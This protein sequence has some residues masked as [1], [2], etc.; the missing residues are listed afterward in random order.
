MLGQLFSPVHSMPSWAMIDADADGNRDELGLL[1]DRATVNLCLQSENFGTTW[2]DLGTPT[3]VAAF[4][5]LGVLVFDLLGD[6]SGAVVESK[7]QVITI[8][9]RLR[10]GPCKHALSVMLLPCDPHL[11][12]AVVALVGGDPGEGGPEGAAG[13]PGRRLRGVRGGSGRVVYWVN[14]A[15]GVSKG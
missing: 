8:D 13:R 3:R 5:S 11:R 7:Q 10:G 14:L 9:H 1:L 6:D 15:R 2:T 4:D 12:R